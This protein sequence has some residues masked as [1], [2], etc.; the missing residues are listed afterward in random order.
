MAKRNRTVPVEHH[1]L[2]ESCRSVYE[3]VDPPDACSWCGCEY[4][5][6]LADLA[7][8]VGLPATLEA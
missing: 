5:E 2:C 3:G 4:F 6:N 7:K 8:D 1:W